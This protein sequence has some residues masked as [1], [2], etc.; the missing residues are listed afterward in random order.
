MESYVH[1]YSAKEALRLSDQANTLA[2]ILLSNI[3]FADKGLI[4][5]PGCGIG[6]QTR[7]LAKNN[8]N[9]QFLSF[10]L[11]KESILRAKEQKAQEGLSNVQLEVAS[12]YDLPY[13]DNSFDGAFACFLLEHLPDPVLALQKLK[14]TLKPES[15]VIA[16]EGDHGS[17][18]CHPRSSAADH[19][20]QCLIDI[21]A[22][23]GG[24]A[25]IGRSLYPLLA[26]AGFREIDIIPRMIYVDSSKPELVEGFTRRTFI[27][28][29]EGVRENAFALGLSDE[30]A[31]TQGIQDLYRT[32]H[33]DGT[34][35]YTFFQ[36]TALK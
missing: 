34:F 29:V 24:N 5:E 23:K 30:K 17:Y 27:A 7:H 1:G 13:A 16:I 35:C 31:W 12:I 18:F 33:Q 2:E 14:R 15:P 4:L 9:T 25:L 36:A 6:A 11:S 10:D 22:R 21:Q 26:S 8:P 20:V 19:V 3:K 32:T 28:M